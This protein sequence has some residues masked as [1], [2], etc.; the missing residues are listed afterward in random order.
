MAKEATKTIKIPATEYKRMEAIIEGVTP[1]LVHRFGEKARKKLADNQTGKPKPAGKKG[2][3]P[4]DPKQDF[5]EARYILSDKEDGFPAAGLKAAMV[6]AGMNNTEIPGTQLKGMFTIPAEFLT[7][8]SAKPKMREDIVPIGGADF[9]YRPEYKKWSMKVPLR[10]N[11]NVISSERV[12]HL[13]V[14]AGEF[15]GLGD[16]RGD[17]G[18][19]GGTFGQFKVKEAREW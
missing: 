3:E 15:P 8:I 19:G 6:R 2:R 12:L 9:R 4:R 14:M 1:L 17:S 5:M 7:I 16:W 13:L 10:Y 18:K 11:P